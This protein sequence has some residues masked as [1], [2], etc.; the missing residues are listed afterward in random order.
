MGP[1]VEING[2]T[3]KLS[4][5]K[6][7]GDYLYVKVQNSGLV[8]ENRVFIHTDLIVLKSF[9]RTIAENW[10][11]WVGTR[12]FTSIEED[13]VLTAT[14]NGRS[15]VVVKIDLNDSQTVASWTVATKLELDLGS[16]EAI[17]KD[18]EKI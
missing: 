9:F 4:I 14:H 3:G 13:F 16:L 17:S 12:H 10:Q 15:A 1:V 5:Q 18:I 11:G 2:S 6:L 7:D 8:A